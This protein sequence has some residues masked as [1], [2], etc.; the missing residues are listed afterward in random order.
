MAGLRPPKSGSVVLRLPHAARPEDHRRAGRVGYIPQHIG[1]VRTRTVLDNVLAGSLSRVPRLRALLGDF[2]SAEVDAA[3]AAIDA[4]GLSEK[5]DVRAHSLSGGERQ[6]VAIARTLLQRP[7]VVFADEFVANLDAVNA[8][9][10]LDLANEL[11]RRGVTLVMALH[12]LDL[13]RDHADSV[14][15][16]RKGS[17]VAHVD[18]RAVS[19]E[20]I[21]CLL[22]D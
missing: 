7:Q 6:R 13:A 16:M 17:L 8:S 21:L 14:A 11:R 10:V 4:V 1:L 15:V 2:P 19:S 22:R 12:N 3:L 18:A 20:D 5:A 9:A